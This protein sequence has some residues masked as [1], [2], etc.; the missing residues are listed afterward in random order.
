M[1]RG[2][3]QVRMATGTRTGIATLLAA[4][5]AAAV[6]TLAG[7]AT[8][9]QSTTPG[10]GGQPTP[11]KTAPGTPTARPTPT[12][13]ATGTPAGALPK[14]T[15]GRVSTHGLSAA[16][17]ILSADK[18]ALSCFHVAAR[19][20][21]TASIAVTEMGVDTGTNHVFAV[22]P[23]GKACAVTELSQSYSANFG[24]SR[25]KIGAVR[26]SVTA[27]TSGGVTLACAGQRLLIPAAVT[28]LY[29]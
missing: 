18:G 20:C 1:K 26:C 28:R 29:M 15:C 13:T 9:S 14:A 27:V 2:R 6:V 16:T 24:G 22:E 5:A 10:P 11:T 25:G 12:K 19:A 4:L 8:S 21:K 17:R 23:G 3:H 7:C